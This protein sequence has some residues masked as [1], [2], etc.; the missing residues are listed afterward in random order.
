MQ[1]S[2]VFIYHVKLQKVRKLTFIDK[3][4]KQPIQ[5]YKINGGIEEHFKAE[6]LN[7]Y[8]FWVN[9]EHNNILWAII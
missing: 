1:L 6:K 5:T 4:L 3:Y 9:K 7:C 2:F 8:E